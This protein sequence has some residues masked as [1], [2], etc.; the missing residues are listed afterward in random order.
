M[1]DETPERKLNFASCGK[2]EVFI[3]AKIGI[4]T[5]VVSGMIRLIL[6]AY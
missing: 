1:R 2:V 4:S 3:N 6:I 5:N